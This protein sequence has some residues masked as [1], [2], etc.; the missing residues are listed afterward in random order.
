VLASVLGCFKIE[1]RRETQHKT[2]RMKK[3]R[4][5]ISKTREAS[6]VGGKKIC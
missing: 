6:R 4:E 2:P 1:K 5:K 3:K